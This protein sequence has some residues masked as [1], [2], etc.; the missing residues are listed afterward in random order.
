MTI[1]HEILPRTDPRLGRNVRHDSRS[2]AYPFRAAVVA[3]TSVLWTRYAPILDQ[4]D[5]G[6]CTA[7]A[8]LGAL[9]SGPLYSAITTELPADAQPLFDDAEAKSVYHAETEDNPEDGVYPPDDPGSDG[10]TA[11][12]VCKA[13]GW[14]SGYTH[15][16]NGPDGVISA[17]QSGPVITG[18]NW[19][20]GMFTPV[21]GVVSI[22][23]AV[24]GG[25]EFV[26][27][28]W[29]STTGLFLADNSWG[30]SWGVDG[31][32]H[33][34]YSTYQRLLSEQG[35]ATVFVPLT[36]PAPAPVADPALA[37]LLAKESHWLSSAVPQ[38]GAHQA[39]TEL[40]RY[41]AS[42]GH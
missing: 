2:L 36:S 6:D 40:K 9:G 3:T 11:A 39:Q 41:L 29:D 7:N 23:G 38:V 30:P 22:S 18:V 15:V 35:D 34:T 19:Y 8:A 28:G 10:L 4:G 27:R 33:F 16:L 32:F 14:I 21:N 42:L 24:A 20:E 12:K 1:R 5:L 26:I 25:H 37:R 13:N 17:L 31:S